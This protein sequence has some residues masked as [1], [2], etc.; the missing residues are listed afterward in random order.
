[1]AD[2]I[3]TITVTQG[4]NPRDFSLLAFGGAG[5]MHAVWLAEELGIDE[6]IIPR[7]PGT[8]SASGMLQT[9]V[10]QDLA[11]N[12]YQLVRQ[13]NLQDL[14]GI[15]AGLVEEG[16]AALQAEAISFEDM[17]FEFSSDMRYVGQE[18]TVNVRIRKEMNLSQIEQAFHDTYRTRYGHAIPGAPVEFVTLR[19]VALGEIK[20]KLTDFQVHQNDREDLIDTRQVYFSGHSYPTPVLRRDWIPVGAIYPGP[21]IIEEDSATTVVPPAYTC[22]VDQFGQIVIKREGSK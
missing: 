2:G 11:C 21:V 4:I 1:M 16:R 7:S 5:P 12:Y 10:R 9:D 22:R 13:A 8:F 20:G 14:A 18:Y 17:R 3:R 19:V 6:V 15:Y